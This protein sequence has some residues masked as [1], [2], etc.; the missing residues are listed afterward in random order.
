M[1]ERLIRPICRVSLRRP[2]LVVLLTILAS[3]PAVHEVRKIRLD[4]D[5]SRL[6]PK[7]SR[8]VRTGRELEKV[9]GGDGGYFSVVFEGDRKDGL[10]RAV[11]LM[12]QR[13][14][15]LSDVQAV[16]FRNP[17][18]FIRR[19]R[20][21][22]VPSRTLRE[23]SDL[24]DHLEAEANPLVVDLD[25]EDDAAGREGSPK[26][27]SDLEA[28]IER[29]MELPE[30]AQSPDGRL[31]GL[32]VRPK[33]GVTSLGA[34][35]DLFQRLA[36]LADDTAREN[37]VTSWVSG[38]NRNKVDIYTQ[39]RDDLNR[40][41]TIAAVGIVVVLI[42]AYRSVRILPVVLVPIGLGLL[43]SYAFVPAL[44]GDLNTITSFL[45]MVLF[46]TG[47][48][49]AV[50]L[51]MRFQAELGSL[52]LDQALFETYRSTGRSIVTSGLSTT[53]GMAVLIFSRF[54]GFSEFGII[55]G[56][57]ILAIF[58]AMFVALPALL[59]LGVRLGLVKAR[60]EGAGH[61]SFVPRPWLTWAVGG[62]ALLAGA[63]AAASLAFDYDFTRLQ[64]E[65]PSAEEA[66]SRH[67]SVYPGF[68]VPGA[69][70]ACA[71]LASLDAA[72]DVLERRRNEIGEGG[73]LGVAT[74]VRD[75]APGP[76]EFAQRLAIVLD[77]KERLSARWTERIEDE[78]KR[79][80]IHSIRDFEPPATAPT[81]DELPPE[82]L[83]RFVA[84]DGSGE[85]IIA[86]DVV[87]RSRDGRTAMAFTKEVYGLTMPAGVR[88][89]TGDKPV[90]AEILWL[91]TEEGPWLVALTFLGI[92]VLVLIDRRS[93]AQTLWVLVPLVAGLLLT[94]GLLAAVGG[95]LNFFNIVVL[96]NLIG[97]AV[98][99]G[100]H[101]FRRWLE[102]GFDTR[103]TQ[104]ELAEAL[105]ASALTTV[106]GY[107]G[108]L[109]AHHAGLRSIGGLAVLG[110]S[111][112][113]FTG[114]VLMPGLL[115]LLTGRL[116]LEGPRG[117]ES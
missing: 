16:E 66:K 8:A 3:L 19:Y 85:W 100:V 61:V 30:R 38:S 44:V 12:A 87:G 7:D 99:N 14:A 57:A 37:G 13:A 69:F 115:G 34:T 1:F 92:F 98:D 58:G 33:K 82:I 53:L 29:S 11:D 59:V 15:A 105:T 81:I 26:D 70:Y 83:R 90:L 31:M 35:R 106:M 54:R 23:V 20:F 48:E 51:V 94:L 36:K 113:W 74:S 116:R 95:K 63:V 101:Y 24:V 40:S 76:E 72:L 86:V 111:C 114:V 50:H 75:F 112:C 97:N 47:V 103:A 56:I 93:L 62:V 28:R 79:R 4:T 80:W 49:F 6:L 96:P 55:A 102:T 42:L 27:T 117:G 108:L 77:L 9:V 2:G 84:R 22:L 68:T 10:G 25:D 52:P 60:A 32:I 39:I 41:G 88:G 89:P 107:A 110:L 46:G 67:R 43:W 21:L 5:L 17:V 65:I 73:I 109:T 104:G 64:P 71:D 78:K 18:E 45:L 91:V